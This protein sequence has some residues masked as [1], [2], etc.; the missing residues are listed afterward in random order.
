MLR[1]PAIATAPMAPVQ[2]LRTAAQDNN[3]IKFNPKGR[4]GERKKIYAN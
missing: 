3:P 2:I 4:R 1:L